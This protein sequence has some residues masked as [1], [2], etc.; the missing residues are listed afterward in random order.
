MCWKLGQSLG[1]EKYQLRYTLQGQIFQ[2]L[3]PTKTSWFLIHSSSRSDCFF[4]VP[5]QVAFTSWVKGLSFFFIMVTM[6]FSLVS[7]LFIALYHL[8]PTSLL[9]CVFSCI[10]LSHLSTQIKW[11]ASEIVIWRSLVAPLCLRDGLLA[12]HW[13]SSFWESS[14]VV[15]HPHPSVATAQ[16]S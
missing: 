8:D 12:P 11:V 3:I 1:E 16:P 7:L 4:N 5:S 9:E 10:T 2:T 14:F 15:R 13:S 6:I